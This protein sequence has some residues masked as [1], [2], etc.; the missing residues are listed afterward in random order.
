LIEKTPSIIS[1]WNDSNSDTK[2]EGEF[3]ETKFNPYHL[4]VQVSYSLGAEK[5][6]KSIIWKVKIRSGN[7]FTEIM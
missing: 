3:Y 4:G 7:D 2:I 1:E 5:S 6:S